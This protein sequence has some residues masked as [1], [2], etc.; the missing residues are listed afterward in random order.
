MQLIR[1]VNRGEVRSGE[2]MHVGILVSFESLKP[3]GW[4]RSTR[5][6]GREAAN[7]L[8]RN[9]GKRLWQSGN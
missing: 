3:Q 5:Y 9:A 1:P 8:G 7:S 4:R 6:D 2:G